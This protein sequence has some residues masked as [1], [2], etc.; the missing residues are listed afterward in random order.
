MKSSYQRD[1][2]KIQYLICNGNIVVFICESSMYMIQVG[3]QTG[4]T[5]NIMVAMELKDGATYYKLKDEYKYMNDEVL[6]LAQ[7][8]K[9]AK[10]INFLVKFDLLL[11][12][13]RDK[14]DYLIKSH[15]RSI[16]SFGWYMLPRTFMPREG[17]GRYYQG[18]RKS[19]M[20]TNL[21]VVIPGL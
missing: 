17:D 7:R 4:W 1:L 15:I 21:C 9:V 3:I 8:F 16:D 14:T 12:E 11:I 19:C 5:N 13:T 20:K 10:V 2:I 6:N 18:L